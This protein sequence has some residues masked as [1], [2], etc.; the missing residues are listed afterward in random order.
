MQ[1]KVTPLSAYFQSGVNRRC[2]LLPGTVSGLLLL[3]CFEVFF[4][5]LV[6]GVA[7]SDG[8]P[9]ERLLPPPPCCQTPLRTV[10]QPFQMCFIISVSVM[11]LVRTIATLISHTLIHGACGLD[12][13]AAAAAAAVLEKLRDLF[14]HFF[15]ILVCAQGQWAEWEVVFAMWPC[16]GISTEQKCAVRTGSPLCQHTS[17]DLQ[18]KSKCVPP[19]RRSDLMS[20]PRCFRA[21]FSAFRGLPHYI[22]PSEHF[23]APSLPFPLW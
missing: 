18:N 22:E 9:V 8:V 3:C 19:Q 23:S 16:R 15:V 4:I 20:F 12:E 21:T 11:W 7:G 1:L 17:F 2:L 13:A 5:Y 14:C 6:A 10:P